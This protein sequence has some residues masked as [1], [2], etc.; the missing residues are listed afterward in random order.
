[1]SLRALRH[2]LLVLALMA[3]ALIPTP[4]AAQVQIRTVAVTGDPAPGVPGATFAAFGPQG[5]AAAGS[6]AIGP[7]GRVVFWAQVAGGAASGATGV[8]SD[9]GGT[10]SPFVLAGQTAPGTSKSFVAFNFPAV[11]DGGQPAILALLSSLQQG[12]WMGAPQAATR[13]ALTG[14]QAPGYPSGVT[15]S[16]APDGILPPFDYPL[17]ISNAGGSIAFN[18]FVSQPRPNNVGL[19]VG[20]PGALT[21]VARFG[22]PAAGLPNTTYTGFFSQPRLNARGQLLFAGAFNKAGGGGGNAIWLGTGTSLAPVAITGRPAPGTATTWGAF[23]LYDP[24]L[25]DAG[26]IAFIANA[27]GVGDGIWAGS[28]GQLQLVALE[29]R[30]APGFSAGHTF[31]S[32]FNPLLDG[33]GG[34]T[35]VAVVAQGGEALNAVYTWRPGAGLTPVAVSGGAVPGLPSARFAAGFPEGWAISSQGDLA[36]LAALADGRTALLYRSAAGSMLPVAVTGSFFRASRAAGTISEIQMNTAEGAQ[37]G[38]PRRLSDAGEVVFRLAFQD[39]SGGVFTVRPLEASPLVEAGVDPGEPSLARC[40]DVEYQAFTR[41][42]PGGGK[43]LFLVATC[44]YPFGDVVLTL[45]G[46]PDHTGAYRLLQTLPGVTFPITT[47]YIGAFSSGLGLEDPP[48]QVQ[49]F[50]AS[51]P[52]T[53][54]VEARP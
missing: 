4:L 47:F 51:G 40:T 10:T 45:E 21:A 37:N 25:N 33:R 5:G 6:P 32:F 17:A 12:V 26:Q 15:W 24:Q 22:D 3:L 46:D 18:S 14:E 54:P 13:A 39:G 36:L 9:L 30:P 2:A 53:V 20:R 7:D 43:T 35:F 48:S 8:W 41:P 27:L 19:W 34:V 52:T 16:P 23:T 29:G 11:G 28:P 42:N 31:N 50:D 1:M 38:Q 49:I 44:S